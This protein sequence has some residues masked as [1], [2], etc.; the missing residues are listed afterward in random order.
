MPSCMSEEQGVHNSSISLTCVPERNAV[1]HL[2]EAS[3]A[4]LLLDASH[5]GMPGKKRRSATTVSTGN[6]PGRMQMLL[7]VTRVGS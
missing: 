1:L 5:A 3:H 7:E 6:L 2:A 4:G